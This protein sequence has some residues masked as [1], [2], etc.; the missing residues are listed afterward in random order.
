[1]ANGAVLIVLAL[2]VLFVV[3][4]GRGQCIGGMV[5]CMGGALPLNNVVP[6]AQS[7]V[8]PGSGGVGANQATATYAGIPQGPTVPAL[9]QGFTWT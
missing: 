1:M 7:T 2:F 8:L 6:S 4:T 5:A 3:S 9:P